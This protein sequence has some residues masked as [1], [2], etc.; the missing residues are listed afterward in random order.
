MGP[1]GKEKPLPKR[2]INSDSNGTSCHGASP[3]PR[4]TRHLHHVPARPARRK[5]KR[6][7]PGVE[8]KSRV[9]PH[10]EQL[11]D[12]LKGSRHRPGLG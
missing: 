8:R 3:L 5:G 11:S 10:P 2:S 6:V 7:S 1:G 12:L 9:E 4:R